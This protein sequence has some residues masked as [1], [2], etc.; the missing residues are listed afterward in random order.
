LARSTEEEAPHPDRFRAS[1]SFENTA[2]LIQAIEAFVST[3]NQHPPP[4]FGWRK[5]QAKGSQLRNTITN[6]CNETL[7]ISIPEI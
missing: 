3:H 6:L 2:Q 5:R 1:E 7:A 4:P